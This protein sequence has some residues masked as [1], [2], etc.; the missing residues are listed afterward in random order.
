VAKPGRDG[1][2]EVALD[3]GFLAYSTDAARGRAALAVYPWEVA[4][5]RAAPD[6]SAVNHVW[7]P[8][9]SV[10]PLGN[11]VRVRV[12]PLA[13]EVTAASAERLGLREGDV[14]VASFKATATRLLPLA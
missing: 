11:R 1:L 7:A 12:G 13:A 4:L 10:V 8:I 6:D 14:V 2:T 5:A 3:A 9:A